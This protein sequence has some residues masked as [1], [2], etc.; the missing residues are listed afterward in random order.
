MNRE[1]APWSLRWAFVWATLVGDIVQISYV[2][3]T[4]RIDVR[5]ARVRRWRRQNDERRL[6]DRHRDTEGNVL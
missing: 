3:G 4:Y 2:D 6:R 1:W 5:S